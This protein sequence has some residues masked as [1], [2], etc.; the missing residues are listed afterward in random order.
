MRPETRAEAESW[1]SKARIDLRA[2]GADLAAA[3]PITSDALFHCQQA[4]EKALKG[5]LAAHEQQ[6]ARNHDLEAHGRKV[7]E[8]EPSLGDIVSGAYYLSVYAS[9]FR[10]PGDS[11]EPGIEAARAGLET[12]TA[13]V[14]TIT[15]LI[16]PGG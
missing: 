10:Y 14:R 12:A 9:E 15:V 1:L 4:I 3:P 6:P 11:V 8:I 7:I 13:L 2:A 16:T 5:F